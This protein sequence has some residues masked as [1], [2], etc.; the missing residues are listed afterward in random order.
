[1]TEFLTLDYATFSNCIAFVDN[2]PRDIP[3]PNPLQNANMG[4]GA[5]KDSVKQVVE[6]ANQGT[7]CLSGCRL[8]DIF[9]ELRHCLCRRRPPILALQRPLPI[10]PN[11]VVILVT[12]SESV[13]TGVWCVPGFGAG[14]EI[15]LEPSELQKEG[16]NPGK[17]H[18]YFL[19]QTLVCTKPW[20]KRDLTPD[21]P[22]LLFAFPV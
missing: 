7:I 8:K 22:F 4:G 9:V 19:R 5:Q 1:M 16:E 10:F 18:F 6:G 17:G 12:P 20:F 13:L 2:F 15:T 14:F 21:P 11:F 3:L